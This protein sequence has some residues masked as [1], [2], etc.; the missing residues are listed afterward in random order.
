MN[1]RLA[2]SELDLASAWE[3]LA[4]AFPDRVAIACGDATRTWGELDDRA[5]RLA[6]A[7]AAHGIGHETK[8]AIALYNGNEYIETEFAAFK[9][10]GVPA[11]VNYRYRADEIHYV[12]QNADAVALVYSV[13]L[14]EVIDE[15]RS[16]IGAGRGA[17]GFGIDEL[18]DPRDTRRVLIETLAQ[19]PPRRAAE[20]PPKFRSITPI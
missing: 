1:A 14:R 10:R 16:K 15:I 11:N 4:G 19:C 13:S 3:G 7:F 2:A 18:I 5:G 20:Q 6:S 9:V 8:V 12:L 17:E